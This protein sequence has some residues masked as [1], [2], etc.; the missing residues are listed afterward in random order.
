ML[1][2]FQMDICVSTGLTEG[3]VLCRIGMLMMLGQAN[4]KQTPKR[5]VGLLRLEEDY[6][7]KLIYTYLY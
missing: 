6:V 2:L 4:T 3:L 1:R 5:L 7:T